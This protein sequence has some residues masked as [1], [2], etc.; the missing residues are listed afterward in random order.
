MSSLLPSP[1]ALNGLT[2]LGCLAALAGAL[3]MQHFEGL[4][5]ARCVSFSALR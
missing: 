4:N 5:P 2:L 1:R 3:Y